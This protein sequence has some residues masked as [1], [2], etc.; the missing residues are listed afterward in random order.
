MIVLRLLAIAGIVGTVAGCTAHQNTDPD[1]VGPR[2][3]IAPPVETAPEAPQALRPCAGLVGKPGYTAIIGQQVTCS[4]GGTDILSHQVSVQLVS[5]P[6]GENPFYVFYS[7][8][9]DATDKAVYYASEASPLFRTTRA[10]SNP[11]H[12]RA[13]ACSDRSK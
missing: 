4:F 1:P 13:Q 7:T 6:A 11:T 3:S 10:A 9:A 5:C 12:E 2:L 8:A